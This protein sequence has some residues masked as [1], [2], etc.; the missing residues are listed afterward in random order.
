MSSRTLSP[1]LQKIAAQAREKSRVFTTL[2]HRIDEELLREAHRLV[3]KD[4][5]PG[6]DGQ[7]GAQYAE[8]LDA[9][10]RDLHDRLRSLR[11]R[12][13]P[14]RRVR[15]PKADGGA[16]PIGIPSFED[17]I[18]QR[19]VVLLLSAVY[20]EDF[21]DFS[22]GFRPGR[23]AHDALDALWQG[24]MKM[25]GGWVIDADIRGFFDAVD[26][27]QL[28]RILRRRINDGGILRLIGKW[29]K[30]GVL[31]AGELSSS[32]S[33]TPQ[34]GVISPL[35]A[36]VY[37]HVVLDAWFAEVVQPRLRGPSF[38]IRYADDFLIVCQREDDA[39][40]VLRVLPKRLAKYGLTLHPDKTRLVRFVQARRRSPTNG[41]A[42]TFTF[43]GFTHHWGRSRRKGWIVKRRT[44]S[45]RLRATQ[46]AIARWCRSYRHLPLADQHRML[47]RKLRGHFGYFG[48]IGN[49]RALRVVYRHTEEV[50][51]KW[52]NR[53]GGKRLLSWE[54]YQRLRRTHPLPRP[55][56]VQRKTRPRAQGSNSYAPGLAGAR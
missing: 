17:K 11:Y 16:R 50:W 51:R 7:T 37:L 1:R 22:Y 25:G 43:L 4:G 40:R 41:G 12:A 14:V 23:G 20:E 38:L 21:Y 42:G 10:L 34:G 30:A 31:E 27:A 47:S 55:R 48:L 49:A 44:A 33:G 24:C 2:A 35:L 46:S 36:N 52:L 9:N 39:R 56:I 32:E 3:R 15:I 18:V 54:Q 5:A 29:L 13:Q 53:R 6:V 8:D 19:A 26:H 45:R 28:Q